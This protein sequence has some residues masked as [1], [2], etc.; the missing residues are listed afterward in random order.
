MRVNLEIDDRAMQFAGEL[1]H[2]LIQAAVTGLV[3]LMD[4][5]HR[6]AELAF[7]KAGDQFDGVFF[8]GRLKVAQ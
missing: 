8:Q 4:Q 6:V 1:A 5:L 3:E 2:F 7:F